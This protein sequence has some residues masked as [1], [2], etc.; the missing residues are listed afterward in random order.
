MG[1]FDYIRR[2]FAAEEFLMKIS[3][4]LQV[5]RLRK[6][7]DLYRCIFEDA[8]EGIYLLTPEERYV[9]VNGALAGMLGYNSPHDLIRGLSDPDHELYAEP[10]HL[11]N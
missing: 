7:E 3:R 8:P 1:A 2:P 5:R 4:A 6:S 10:E 9:V 11:Q